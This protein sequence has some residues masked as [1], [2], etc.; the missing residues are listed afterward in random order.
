M[1]I[2]LAAF[3]PL[4]TLATHKYNIS[5]GPVS[6]IDNETCSVYSQ[7]KNLRIKFSRFTKILENWSPQNFLAIQYSLAYLYQ[8]L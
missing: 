4:L 6:T 8:E 3:I 1:E 7:P 5:H 2:L